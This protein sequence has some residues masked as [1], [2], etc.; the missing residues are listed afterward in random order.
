MCIRDRAE[1][2]R[3]IQ[4]YATE[5]AGAVGISDHWLSPAEHVWIRDHAGHSLPEVQRATLRLAAIR[6]AG[7]VS[8]GALALG[9]SHTAM[10]KWLRSHR[11]PNLALLRASN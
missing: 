4:E 3:L 1:I 7:S 2:D 9:I 11:Y 8:A 10:L 6:K 5:A